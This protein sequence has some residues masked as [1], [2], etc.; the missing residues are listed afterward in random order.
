MLTPLLLADLPTHIGF[1]LQI[2]GG[3]A[4]ALSGK[5]IFLLSRFQKRALGPVVLIGELDVGGFEFPL[6]GRH[7]GIVCGDCDRL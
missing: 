6:K 4:P 5:L 7:H 1:V 3:R 2:E